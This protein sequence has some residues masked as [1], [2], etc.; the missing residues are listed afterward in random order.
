MTAQPR[1]V[2]A[3][4]W[5]LVVGCLA[6]SGGGG[7]PGAAGTTAVPGA[8]GT[9]ASAGTA[10]TTAMTGAAGTTAMTGAG[11]TGLGSGGTASA[12]TTG[13]GVSGT[14]GGGGRGGSSAAGTGTGTAGT[15]AG[16]AGT[17][18]G[19]GGVAAP[20]GP[21]LIG[22]VTFTPPSQSYKGTLMVAMA[23]A[24]TGVEIR[25]TTDGTLPTASSMLYSA[26]IA[27]SATTQLRAQPFLA[28]AGA[29]LVSTGLYIARTF[30]HS[31]NLPIILLD[32]YGKGMPP[33]PANSA[34]ANPYRAAAVLVYEPSG[35]TADVSRLPTMVAR[36]GYHLRGQSSSMFPQR[37]Y[38]VEF[39]D[40]A[41]AD[42]K[43]PLLGMPADADWALIAPYYDRSLLRNPF[44]YALG[45]EMALP[46]PRT[47]FAEVYINY[48]N[49]P[50][51]ADDYQGIYW[52]S[53]TLK[54][55][56]RR[57]PLAKLEPTDITPPAVTGGYMFKFDFAAT[58]SAA[59]KLTCAG[60]DPIMPANATGT[61]PASGGNCWIDLEV[62]EPD[63]LATQQLSWL[64]QYVQSFHDALHTT[65][66]GDYTQYIDVASFVDLMIVTELT[67]NLDAYIR[68]AYYHKDRD[69]KLKG[70]PLWDYNFAYGI[71]ITQTIDPRGGLQYLVGRDI[72]HWFPK[73]MGDATFAAQVRTRWKALRQTVLSNVSI[74]A[75]IA[76]L[77]APLQAAAVARDYAKWPVSRVYSATGGIA[78]VVGPT[79]ATFDAQVTAFRTF[80]VD[81]AAWID[82]QWP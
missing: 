26:P 12:G 68:S 31:S 10:G 19:T 41:D 11:G 24:L 44:T 38:K 22:D 54:I 8:A 55:N 70:G 82:T 58:D 73:L 40:N 36:A 28:G 69:G 79:A 74:D 15:G 47:Q 64:N 52:V 65:P 16:T 75:R 61:R 71:G 7:N 17:G 21:S 45:Q 49:R 33:K 6:P 9:T 50:M 80:V 57:L 48:A 78:T 77:R 35:G 51:S 32:G 42:A 14:T 67:R 4:G 59:P 37:P 76:T 53:E 5:T 18:A 23:T 20:V 29:G 72:N 60:S 46:V 63:T 62:S 25:Y 30:D 2:V 3:V 34:V 39:W 66:I 43:F 56:G 27:L 1:W 13:S 81:R